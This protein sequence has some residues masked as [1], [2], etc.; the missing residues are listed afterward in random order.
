MDLTEAYSNNTMYLEPRLQEYIRRKNFNKENHIEPDIPEEKEFCI[1]KKDMKVINRHKKGKNVI[2]DNSNNQ[3]FIKSS[4][5]FEFGEDEFQQ[6]PRY[7]R[8]V[9]KMQKHKD[10]KQSTSN[11][12]NMDDCYTHFHKTNPYDLREDKKPQRISKPYYDENG[13][14]EFNNNVFMNSREFD[15]ENE[16]NKYCYSTNFKNNNEMTYHH[17]PKISYR[18]TLI[19]EKVNG[20]LKHNHNVDDIIGDYD[21]YNKHLNNTYSYLGNQ[22]DKNNKRERQNTYKSLPFSYGN[23]YRDISVEDSIRGGFNV[24]S[25]K[26]IGFKNPFENQFDYISKDISDPNHTVQMYPLSSRGQNKQIARPNSKSIRADKR[27]R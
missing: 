6:D 19:H 12:S 27:F 24:S 21:S 20:G 1:T 22:Y 2:Y 10:A 13:N 5:K 7:Q 17:K 4:G 15:N 8:L 9:K 23:G 3:H 18:N 11:F 14:N 16:R 26:S 25:K